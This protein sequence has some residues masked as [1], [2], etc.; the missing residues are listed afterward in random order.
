MEDRI[1]K[2]ENE[3]VEL[4]QHLVVK[5]A[6]NEARI[7]IY[8]DIIRLNTDIKLDKPTVRTETGET[9]ESPRNRWVPI[10][11][12]KPEV[13]DPVTPDEVEPRTS[14]APDRASEILNRI[15]VN[16]NYSRNLVELR[17][18]RVELFS[19]GDIESYKAVCNEHKDKLL[20]IFAEKGFSD[21]KIESQIRKALTSFEV[22][23][24][25]YNNYFNTHLDVDEVKRIGDNLTRGWVT[26]THSAI[27]NSD[28]ILE[29]I[30]NYGIALFPLKQTLQRILSHPEHGPSVIYRKPEKEG[31]DSYSFYTLDVIEGETKKW[32]MDCRLEDLTTLIKSDL[33]P[34]C[35][36][37]FKQIYKDVFGDNVYRK[38]YKSRCQLTEFDCEQ[39]IANILILSSNESL[40]CLLQQLVKDSAT[41]EDNPNYVYNIKGDDNLQKRK[42]KEFRATTQDYITD[43]FDTITP[44][45]ISEFKA[46]RTK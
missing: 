22:R 15:K 28:R 24:I 7:A 23:L 9:G 45:D 4:R 11:Q 13:P 36:N 30:H 42:W 38:D 37:M 25:R 6:V 17:T 19:D 1:S 33:Y 29:S 12:P 39:L 2:L 5:D 26:H 21:K 31:G 35:T 14:S 16:K 3:L 41:V 46:S 18:L 10:Q 32:V 34:Y 20:V 27:F 40:N 8:R 43:L 44:S